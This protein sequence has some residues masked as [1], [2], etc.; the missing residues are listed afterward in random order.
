MLFDEVDAGIGGKVATCVAKELV[1]LSKTKQVIT[2]THLSQ[3]ASEGDRHYK[4]Y[5]TEENGRTVSHIKLLEN[6]ERVREIARILSGDE[7][8]ISLEHARKMLGELP[9]P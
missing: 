6:E 3:I 1:E 4:V 8:E 7:S 5:K 9:P 2:I